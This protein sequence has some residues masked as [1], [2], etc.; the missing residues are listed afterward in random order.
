MATEVERKRVCVSIPCDIMEAIEGI[1]RY[2][3]RSPASLLV[4]ILNMRVAK[5]DK[6]KDTK[7]KK[8]KKG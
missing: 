8:K 3:S 4:K 1:A 5:A 2:D 6:K 7:K